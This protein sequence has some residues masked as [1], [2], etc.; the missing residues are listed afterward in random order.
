MM[1]RVVKC[2][3]S[4]IIRFECL[5]RREI[6]AYLHTCPLTLVVIFGGD[7]EDCVLDIFIFVY[8]SLVEAF[9]E[10]RRIV[11]LVSYSNTDEFRHCNRQKEGCHIKIS[12]YPH[13]SSRYESQRIW[14]AGNPTERFKALVFPYDI[15]LENA[16][17]FPT[18]F[19]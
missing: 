7:S 10:V 3:V 1:N 15:S 9:V 6:V 11:V 14:V 18:S 13:V 8:F 4:Q 16:N 17:S 5:R 19:F 12:F 2:S